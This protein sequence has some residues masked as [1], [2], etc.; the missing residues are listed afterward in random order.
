[1]IVSWTL[2]FIKDASCS[3]VL[4]PTRSLIRRSN[5]PSRIWPENH[6]REPGPSG[7]I[8]EIVNCYRP[9]VRGCCGCRRRMAGSLSVCSRRSRRSLPYPHGGLTAGTMSRGGC[10]CRMAK[11]GV[12]AGAPEIWAALLDLQFIGSLLGHVRLRVIKIARH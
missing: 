11:C 2:A 7:E 10:H 9:C 8:R 3:V 6:L 4:E 5:I 12:P 1:M